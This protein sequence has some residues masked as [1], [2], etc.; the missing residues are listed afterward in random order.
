M[1]LRD[2]KGFGPKSEEILANVNVNS[3]EDF[4]AVDP[5]DLYKEL[6][7]KVKGTGLNSIYAII[8]AREGL[9]WQEVSR[10]RKSEILMRLDDM[11]IA[12]K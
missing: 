5:F 9:H 2:L 6:K 12:P 8:G 3:V 4:M 10:T 1:R 11:G 7:E